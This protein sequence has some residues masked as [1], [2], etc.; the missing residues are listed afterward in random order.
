[1]FVRFVSINE[2][3]STDWNTISIAFLLFSIRVFK[4]CAIYFFRSLFHFTWFIS[5]K[6]AH[7][8]IHSHIICVC[9]IFK[10]TSWMEWHVLAHDVWNGISTVRQYNCRYIGTCIYSFICTSLWLHLWLFG[11]WQVM[12]NAKIITLHFAARYRVRPN[13]LIDQNKWTELRMGI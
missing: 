4:A 1:M 3:F 6:Q 5:H 8:H 11:H 12:Y 13:E 9:L 7:K 2:D 10:P